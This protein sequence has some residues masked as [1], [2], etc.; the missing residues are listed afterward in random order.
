MLQNSPWVNPCDNEPIPDPH[1]GILTFENYCFYRAD[2]NEFLKPLFGCHLICD[3]K[4]DQNQCH[5]QHLKNLCQQMFYDERTH[6]DHD[7]DFPS[8]SGNHSYNND[9]DY[10]SEEKFENPSRMVNFQMHQTS[11]KTCNGQMNGMQWWTKCEPHQ[12]KCSGNSSADLPRPHK[13]SRKLGGM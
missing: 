4:L 7:A 11:H 9:D 13:A 12:R 10:H 6:H 1:G 3:C 8:E 2:S 5:A